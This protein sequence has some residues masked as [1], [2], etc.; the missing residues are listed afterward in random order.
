MRRAERVRR[1][2]IGAGLLVGLGTLGCGGSGDGLNRVPVG[3]VVRLNGE[4]LANGMVTLTPVDRPEPVVTGIT[5]DS[6]RF[7]IDN[8]DGPVPGPHKVQ[9]WARYE[10]GKLV[11]D[12]D[13]PQQRIPEVAERIPRQYNLESTLVAEIRDGGAD[14]LAFELAGQPSKPQTRRR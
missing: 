6:G 14:D 10:T 7:T 1:M 4:P 3:G 13:D 2:V 9:I 8:A 12:P 11:R 5:D